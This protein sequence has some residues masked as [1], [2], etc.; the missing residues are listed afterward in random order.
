[1]RR[2]P[3]V[4]NPELFHEKTSEPTFWQGFGGIQG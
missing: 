2:H 3:L 1:M 4:S